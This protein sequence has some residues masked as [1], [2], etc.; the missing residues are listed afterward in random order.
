MILFLVHCVLW[1]V[2]SYHKEH[3]EFMDEER[4]NV[5]DIVER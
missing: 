1:P 4:A 3:V 2:G 5:K